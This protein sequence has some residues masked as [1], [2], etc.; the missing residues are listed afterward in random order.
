MCILN[1]LNDVALNRLGAN[2]SSGSKAASRQFITPPAA[3]GCIP[4]TQRL[5]FQVYFLSVRF[6]QKRSFKS[7]VS[8]GFECLLSAKSSRSEGYGLDATPRKDGPK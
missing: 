2:V 6:H 1:L 3:F 4:A 7:P 5:I 8:N